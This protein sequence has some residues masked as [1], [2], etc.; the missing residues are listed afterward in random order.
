[1][2]KTI[3]QVTCVF[4]LSAIAVLWA[5]NG[6]GTL[7]GKVLN[8]EG[9]PIPNATVTV[10]NT[11][12][13]MSQKVLTGPHGSF[14]ISGLAPGTYRIDVDA[15]GF[16]RTSQQDVHV[17]STAPAVF[18]INMQAGNGHQTVQIKGHA[19][20]VQT[21]GG[22]MFT[23][24]GQRTVNELPVIDR[25]SQGIVGLPT[26][27]TPP[28]PLLDPVEDPDRNRFFSTNGQSITA[29]TWEVDGLLNAE[30]FRN[31]AIRVIPDTA[32]TQMYIATA[33][34]V[35][36]HGFDGGAWVNHQTRQGSNDVH[37]D[38]F[39]YWSGD[40]FR[41]RDYFNTYPGSVNPHFVYNQFGGD[42]GAPIVKD[43]TFIFGSYQGTYQSG[44][45]SQLGTVPVAG[46]LTGNFSAIPGLTLFNPNSG[47][48]NGFLRTPFT[49]GIIPSNLI[50]PAAATIA[51]Y[52]P[53]PNLP[54]FVNNYATNVPFK[55]NTN[56]ADGRIDQHFGDK[57]V[58]FLRYGYTNTWNLSDSPL[59]NVIGAAERGR[60][61]AQNAAI[62]FERQISNRLISDLRF[63]YNRWDQKLNNAADQTA[64]GAPGGLSNFDNNLVGINIPGLAPIGA[65]GFLPEHA[66]DNTFNWVWGWTLQ[67]AHNN[68][69]WG[70]DIRRIRSDGF[71]NAPF[72]SEFGPNGTT[73]FG[74]GTTMLNSATPAAISQ[75]GELYNSYAAFLMGAPTQF[76]IANY[77]TTPTI[78]QSQYGAF[79]GDSVHPKSW[80]SLDFGVRYE[81]YSPL[82]ARG[83]GGA[84][85]Y[86]PLNN[87]YSYAGNGIAGHFNSY[88]LD[89][90]APRFGFAIR[91]GDKTVV[92]GGYGIN[93]FAS[94]YM[95]AGFVPPLFGTST[96][97]AGTYTAAVLGS[98]FSG[99]AVNPVSPPVLPL[100]N[101]TPAT[102][103]PTAFSPRDQD[104][105]YVQTF[106]LQV[107]REFYW[108]TVLS[109][110]YVGSLGRHLLGIQE[111]NA[112][113]AGT[114]ILGLPFLPFGRTASTLFYDNG[115]TDN[116]NSLQTS[117]SKRFSHGVSFL[118]SYT[119]SKALGYTSSNNMLYNPSNPSADY[120][121]LDYDRQSV[122]T[123][124]HAVEIP[125]GKQHNHI[126][127]MLVSGWQL[128][129]IFS[130]ATGLPLTVTADPLLC[131]CPG[132]T[133]FANLNGGV[134]PV[135][136]SGNSYLNPAA[137]SAPAS[138]TFGNLGRGAI[139]GQGYRNYN[140]SLFK[141]FRVHD[142]FNL[143]LRGEAYNLTNTPR[144]L[145]PV[146]NVN[147]PDFG[148][149]V[150]TING[151]GRQVNVA[152]RLMF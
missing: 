138:G 51:S 129:G 94:P 130:W 134:N 150:N 12:T 1:M 72:A 2:R 49:T 77:A 122:F 121:P 78:R 116:Y 125:T 26:G 59:G 142:H 124:S 10:T 110:G 57:N 147:S 75:F 32:I 152:A 146:T 47:L 148:Q 98:P 144:F 24:L 93:Y 69:R 3:I 120:G 41:A 74:P 112:A 141:N 66:V 62:D 104:T 81:V 117:L 60:L 84:Q 132:N 13:N 18:N 131:N 106:S 107:Q 140:M 118:A 30:P 103:L 133:V 35:V 27:I 7:S 33:N 38:L 123:L 126:M 36:E 44:S 8:S 68:L 86:N 100:L 90:V 40:I 119:W 83:L 89:S 71:T 20:A 82:S 25:S 21:E 102:N 64:L 22:E 73:Y 63:G 143:Q 48:T 9:T 88:D 87:T 139:T 17:T 19:P 113:P 151:F 61:V 111:S 95:Y 6:N 127:E 46:T 4:V 43:K 149:N 29:N 128:N 55:D 56:K 15:V 58:V 115:L 11:G 92:R 145:S 96:G 101:G 28:L 137:F 91:A 37:G 45:L 76:G 70:T 108:G 42:A 135:I 99:T 31:T 34:Q 5:Q 67:T 23:V 50:N 53:L 136:A 52:I 97:V 105:P 114:G 39:E 65:A 85:F 14:S 16:K 79:I 54:G 109:A 80:I